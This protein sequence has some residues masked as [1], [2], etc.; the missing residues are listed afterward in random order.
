[1]KRVLD[2]L[3]RI[4]LGLGLIV[5]AFVVLDIEPS[6]VLGDLAEIDLLELSLLVV[7]VFIADRV[8]MTYK[9]GLLLRAAGVVVPFRE[10]FNV[11]LISGF[12]GVFLPASIGADAARFYYLHRKNLDY[13]DVAASIVV[14]RFLGFFAVLIWAAVTVPVLA[15]LYPEFRLPL[16][17]IGA[18]ILGL[19]VFVALAMNQAFAQRL[20]RF[21]P[22]LIGARITTISTRL[23][24]ALHAYRGRQRTLAIFL[25]LSIIE[26]SAP[27]VIN[28]FF[29][30][31]LNIEVSLV[32]FVLVYPLILIFVRL[33]ISVAGI[34]TTEWSYV[35]L[36]AVI[37]MPVEAALSLG[38]LADA[39][40]ILLLLL[41]G[42]PPTFY[43]IVTWRRAK[44]SERAAAPAPQGA[45]PDGQIGAGHAPRDP[46]G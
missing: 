3:L 10:L 23:Y 25:V 34:G 26:T 17:V 8:L 27:I 19:P 22:R 13:A 46:E 32:S 30:W 20:G 35:Y 31:A 16:L 44:R 18:L 1:M 24:R 5:L 38:V 29:V 9:W 4:G 37:G 6:A 12:V 43:Y 33:P 2:H 15:W 42:G 45:G 36:Y 11:Y 41:F 28:I 21:F 14:E 40:G 39:A 7:P